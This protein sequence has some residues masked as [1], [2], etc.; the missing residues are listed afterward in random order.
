MP[1]EELL[2]RKIRF[3]SAN[4]R[5]RGW[6]SRGRNHRVIQFRPNVDAIFDSSLLGRIWKV[7]DIAHV[8]WGIIAIGLLNINFVEHDLRHFDTEDDFRRGSREPMKLGHDIVFIDVIDDVRGEL[9]QILE[10]FKLWRARGHRGNVWCANGRPETIENVP[11]KLLTIFPCCIQQGLVCRQIVVPAVRWQIAA[12][13]QFRIRIRASGRLRFTRP[14][15]AARR[16]RPSYPVQ[17]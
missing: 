17:P 10:R 4:C 14:N 6:V 3:R 1:A 13:V 16:A 7:W 9:R 5:I 8:R 2:V 12:I 15:S 11:G